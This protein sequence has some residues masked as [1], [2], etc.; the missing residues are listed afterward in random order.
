[1][2]KLL[3][4]FRV[5]LL[6]LA[7]GVFLF[8]FLTFV[9]KGGLASREALTVHAYFRD[10][11]G[12]GKKSRVQIAGIAVGEVADITLEGT[13]AKLTLRVRRDV[14]LR[15]DASL[16]KRSESLLGDYL[17]DLYRGSE[18]APLMV[19]GG[20]IKRV[21]DTGGMEA[22]FNTLSVIT[23]DIQQVTTALRQV[24]G[25]E[26]GAGSLQQIVENL[27]RLS[28]TVESTVRE[29]AGKLNDILRNFE[30]VARDVRGITAG[31][32][33]TIRDILRNIEG[34]TR[35]TR[36]VLGTVKKVL[37]AGEG[38]M[39]E[40]VASLKQTLGHLDATLG[41][42]EEVTRKVKQGE[43]PVG[44]LLTDE[45]L[46]QKISES[47]EDLSDFS[48]RLTRLQAEVSLRSDYL[49]W[50]GAAKNFI[51][52]RLIPRPDKYYLLE[53][54][55][56]PRGSVRTVRVESDPPSSGEPVQQT[57]TTTTDALKFSAQL[58]KR[59]SFTTLRFG[60]IESTGGLGAD[61]SFPL[62]FFW[63]SRWIEDALTLKVDAFNFSVVQLD[64]PRLRA[65]LR[66]VPYEHL[67]LMA[68]ADDLLNTQ[69]RDRQSNRLLSGRDYF[70]GVGIFF[71]DQDLKALLTFAPSP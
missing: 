15:E 4:P 70:V 37:G 40:S 39:K 27:I 55:D 31:E 68:G 33:A 17:I 16:T 34:V 30:G 47:V 14:G 1:M 59:F 9:R 52:L 28:Q 56:D 69:A 67:F 11:S 19:D 3:T 44:V 25:G 24:L 53:V 26:K 64:Y 58:A 38:E 49:Y 66:L 71:T 20:E 50:Q 42:L 29:S 21:I 8:I 5:G 57:V 61:F 18:S 48:S 36:D 6:V 7:S 60:I 62:K 23:S 2:K 46:G 35:D 54:V 41:N 63:Y 13:R 51:S 32:E 12:L 45:R 10:A 65:T 22:V 43:G